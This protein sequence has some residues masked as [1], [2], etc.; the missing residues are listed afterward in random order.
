MSAIGPGDWV[1]CVEASGAGP[2]EVGRIY[3][4][5]DVFPSH[6][7]CTC[8]CHG[9]EVGGLNLI[10]LPVSTVAGWIHAHCILCF[11]PIYRPKADFIESLK[12]PA[13]AEEPA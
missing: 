13:P 6:P 11:R 8:Y 9:R 12:R 5:A 2:L 10:E 3:Q 4:V 7:G 1:E